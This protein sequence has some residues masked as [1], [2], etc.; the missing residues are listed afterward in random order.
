M[1]SKTNVIN[2]LLNVDRKGHDEFNRLIGSDRMS[3]RS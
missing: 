3:G 1:G 2:G